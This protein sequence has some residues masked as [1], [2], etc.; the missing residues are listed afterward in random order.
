MCFL[1]IVFNIA[2]IPSFYYLYYSDSPP[3]TSHIVWN[4]VIRPTFLWETV[5]FFWFPLCLF[6]SIINSIINS[7]LSD[8]IKGFNSLFKE[9]TNTAKLKDVRIILLLVMLVGA[10]YGY[11]HQLQPPHI[12]E[13]KVAILD[14]NPEL[15]GFKIALISDLHYGRGQNLTELAATMASAATMRPDLVIMAGDLVDRK[16]SFGSDFRIPLLIFREVP[17]GVFGVL[18]NHDLKV[19]SLENLVSNLRQTNLNILQN[20]RVNLTNVP[21]TLIGFSDPGDQAYKEEQDPPRRLPLEALS[22]PEPRSGDLLIVINHRP[23]AVPDAVKYGAGLYLAGHTHGGQIAF[24]WNAQLNLSS[25][26]FG[27]SYT[28]G[29]Y[30]VGN[31]TLYVTK[32]LSGGIPARLFAWPE[33]TI[34]TLTT[35]P[36]VS[37]TINSSAQ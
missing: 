30:K 9:N 35:A 26:L 21:I 37:A 5:H 18:G 7:R 28:S 15:E 32:G 34:L 12:N 11:Y 17:N 20:Q 6:I 4:Y 25:L 13:D 16:A 33:I 19:D 24:P 2:A 8:K 22:G 10:A 23:I 14:L 1:Y 31:L 27:Y 3:P 29:K 36:A